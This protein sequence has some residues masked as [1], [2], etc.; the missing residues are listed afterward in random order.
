ML[1]VFDVIIFSKK[2]IH[3]IFLQWIKQNCEMICWLYM[4]SFQIFASAA[5]NARKPCIIYTNGIGNIRGSQKKKL[6][7]HNINGNTEVYVTI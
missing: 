2:L 3:S 4:E 5:F 7:T 1:R 6:L